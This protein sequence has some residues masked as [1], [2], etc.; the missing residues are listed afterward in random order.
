M[1]LEWSCDVPGCE[2][3]I[4]IEMVKNP[5]GDKKRAE[6][7]TQA[8]FNRQVKTHLSTHVG[9]GSYAGKA[10]PIPPGA[11]TPGPDEVE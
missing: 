11:R 5:T 4:S 2:R 6:E 1:K 7:E 9:R 3:Y 10:V 8:A